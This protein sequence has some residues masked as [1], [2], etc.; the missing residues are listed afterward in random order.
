MNLNVSVSIKLESGA[1]V[2]VTA[3]QEKEITNAIKNIIIGTQSTVEP[4]KR[5]RG[6]KNHRIWTTA[7]D[8]TVRQALMYGNNLK[9]NE[10]VMKRSSIALIAAQLGRTK[11]SVRNRIHTLRMAAKGA[12]LEGTYN[13]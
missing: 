13:Q 10:R 11:S 12:T 6:K 7:E 2:K 4:V 9:G 8:D 1:E 5:K 3:A